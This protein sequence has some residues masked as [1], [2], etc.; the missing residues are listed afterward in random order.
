MAL[1]ESRT[2]ILGI[3]STSENAKAHLGPIIS[4]T[5]ELEG[6]TTDVLIDT[7]SPATIVSLEFLIEARQKQKPTNQSLEE[8]EESFKSSISAPEVTLQNYG[9]DQINIVGQTKVVIKRGPYSLE[10]TVQVQ[11]HGPLPILIGTNLQP[12]LGFL[13][14][15]SDPEGNAVDLLSQQTV[16]LQSEGHIPPTAVVHLVHPV[17]LPANHSRLV[18]S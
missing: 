1:T 12:K 2:R 6:T 11:R 10:T 15:Q 3:S 18:R 13:F 4:T 17:H 8:W 5:V 7:G 9:G 16:Q 14:L